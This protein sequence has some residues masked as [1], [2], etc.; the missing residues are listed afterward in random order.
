MLLLT[1][2][3]TTVLLVSSTAMAKYNTDLEGSAYGTFEKYM[4]EPRISAEV[5]SGVWNLKIQDGVVW[6]YACVLEKNLDL[7]E[8]S[9][10]GS[11]DVL[12]YS[13]AGKPFEVAKEYDEMFKMEVV[14]VFA[15][16]QVKKQWAQ[17]D[18]TYTTQTWTSWGQ[19]TILRNGV[20]YAVNNPYD[21]TWWKKGKVIYE[22]FF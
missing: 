18:G 7:S 10:V 15:N 4:G 5:V 12:E 21:D 17:M 8:G 19:I 2:F 11:V 6:Y 9:P 1:C 14:K 3:L 20:V 16:M 13:I 22:D